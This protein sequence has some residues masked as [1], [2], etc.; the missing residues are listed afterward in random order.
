MPDPRKHAALK[1][2]LAIIAVVIFQISLFWVDDND[3]YWSLYDT[4]TD[5]LDLVFAI[6]LFVSIPYS[7]IQLKTIT[8][9]IVLW[10]I[11]GTISQ[12]INEYIVFY[13]D[14]SVV[15]GIFAVVFMASAF[16]ARFAIRWR[17]QPVDIVPGHFYEVIGKPTNMSQLGVAM[18]TG[19]GGAFGITDGVELWHYS[20]QH[21]SR[22]R[23]KL[24]PTYA[25]G[26]MVRQICP[27]SEEKYDEL[28]ADNGQ[29]FTLLRNCL[30]FRALSGRW[31]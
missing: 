21:N 24:T 12:L 28:D 30:E 13:S 7:A 8:A 11:Y 4:S 6:A 29:E 9:C 20:K 31:Q 10:N 22:V 14:D 25:I 19:H 26:K 23:E 16:L 27:T 3:M 18:Y 5:I 15:G 17:V 1:W 2:V